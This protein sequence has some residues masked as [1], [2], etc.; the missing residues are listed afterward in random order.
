MTVIFQSLNPNSQLFPLKFIFLE[1]EELTA[2]GA[3]C[4]T[5]Y[6]LEMSACCGKIFLVSHVQRH[7]QR[8][9]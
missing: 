4:K 3:Y 7:V 6:L 5:T 1:Y 8:F 2:P 9:I